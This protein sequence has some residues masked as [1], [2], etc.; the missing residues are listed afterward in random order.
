MTAAM[1]EVAATPA[2]RVLSLADP[3]PGFP[4]QRDFALV[5]A[6]ARVSCSGCSPSPPTARGS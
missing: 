1:V 3:L 6:D 2:V 4:G 5:A